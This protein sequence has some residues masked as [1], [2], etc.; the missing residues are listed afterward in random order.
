[1][2]RGSCI[3]PTMIVNRAVGRNGSDAI[4]FVVLKKIA[5]DDEPRRRPIGRDDGVRTLDDAGGL[6]RVGRRTRNVFRNPGARRGHSRKEASGTQT[7]M[8][9]R[10]YF[11]RSSPLT[12]LVRWGKAGGHR[13]VLIRRQARALLRY[14]KARRVKGW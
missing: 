4:A 10:I 13:N 8:I 3:V 2:V 12:I 6:F 7:G 11:E 5:G 9:G 14:F 1:M